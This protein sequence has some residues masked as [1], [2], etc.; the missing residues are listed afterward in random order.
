[1]EISKN[2]PVKIINDSTINGF[3][4]GKE[5]SITRGAIENLSEEELA[6]IVGHEKAHIQEGHVGKTKAFIR[7]KMQE[8]EVVAE[9]KNTKFFKKALKITGKAIMGIG[10]FSNLSHQHE[11]EADCKATEMLREKGY[12]GIGGG[13]LMDRFNTPDRGSSLTHP[14]PE[15]RK[16]KME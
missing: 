6:F 3:T 9:D 4:D 10:A 12:T 11:Y 16:K 5:I 1:M 8:I 2:Q 7:R 14:H 13:E 15:S